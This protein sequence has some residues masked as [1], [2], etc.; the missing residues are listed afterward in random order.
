M[1]LKTL[2][3]PLVSAV[4]A[5]LQSAG[6]LGPNQ[7]T[8]CQQQQVA[9]VGAAAATDTTYAVSVTLPATEDAAGYGLTSIVYTL[10]GRVQD[11]P[12]YGSKR[13]LQTFTP[14]KGAAERSKGTPDYGEGDIVMA[15]MPLDAG[16]IILKAAEASPNR[17]S[18]KAVS[19][20]GEI[21]YFQVLVTSWELAAAKEGAFK[22]RTAHIA[23]QTKPVNIPAI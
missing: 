5:L 11:F 21:D 9:H 6:L 7:P 1:K 17:Y 22:L 10:I 20:D 8:P 12:S 14:I 3:R 15:D 18:I 23:V 4:S 16:Q 19:P 2:V 13:A